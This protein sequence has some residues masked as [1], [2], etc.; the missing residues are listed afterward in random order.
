M[1]GRGQ[2]EWGPDLAARSHPYPLVSGA[3]VRGDHGGVVGLVACLSMAVAVGVTVSVALALGL[4]IA[5]SR[6][7]VMTVGVAVAMVESRAA[8]ATGHDLPMLAG[9][10][11][12]AWPDA[13]LS[14]L[15]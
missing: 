1:E 7:L 13:V 5:F 9:E 3:A 12:D 2:T 4:V 14:G 8:R 6:G 10:S 11:A 15:E